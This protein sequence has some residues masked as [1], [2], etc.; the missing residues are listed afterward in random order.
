MTDV[1]GTARPLTMRPPFSNLAHGKESKREI[2][3]VTPRFKKI[4]ICEIN[5]S[6]RV[7]LKKIEQ[8][9]HE[10]SKTIPAG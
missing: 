4:I 10:Q 5:K 2:N 1:T 8:R 6:V 3:H 9:N 7:V